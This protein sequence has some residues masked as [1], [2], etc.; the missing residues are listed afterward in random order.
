MS[1]QNI[2]CG[3]V[4]LI[5]WTNVGKSTLLNALTKHRIAITSSK[6]QTTRHRL[7]GVT[8]GPG[9]QLVLIDTPG[10]HKASSELSRQM[11][12][13][14]WSTID[15]TDALIWMLFP[16]RDPEFQIETILQHKHRIQ[17]PLIVVIN[18]VDKIQRERLLPFMEICNKKLNPDEIIPISAKTGENLDRLMQTV[19]NYLPPSPPMYPDDQI[20]DRT[21]R[22]ITSEIIRQHIIDRTYQELPHVCAV[23]IESFKETHKTGFIQIMAVIFIEKQSQKGIII[24]KGGQC[25]KQ[26]GIAAR[27]DLESYFG[28]RIDLKLWVKVDSNWRNNMSSLKRFGFIDS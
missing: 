8:N 17:S 21:E 5:G 24:G 3:F 16:D 12:R 6:P 7:I 11:L 26:I 27:K 14:T 22:F 18:K 13:V 10:I 20:T 1:D 23:Q 28:T 4:G 2:R 15:G 19:I 9:Y 25:L